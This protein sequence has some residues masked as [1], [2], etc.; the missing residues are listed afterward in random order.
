[1]I[2][3]HPG[4]PD[5]AGGPPAGPRRSIRITSLTAL[6]ALL[7]DTW[8]EIGTPAWSHAAIRRCGASVRRDAPRSPVAFVR[9]FGQNHL[10]FGS[11]MGTGES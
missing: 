5:V 11:L 4:G 8:T 3:R 9:E 1:M 2:H 7:L 10:W 6:T